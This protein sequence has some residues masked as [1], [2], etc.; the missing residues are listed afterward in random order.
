ME[1]LVRSE[2]EDKK[3]PEVLESEI[4]ENRIEGQ[5]FLRNLRKNYPGVFKAVSTTQAI[6]SLL[7]YEGKTIERLQKRGRIDGGEAAR[8]MSTIDQRFKQ[9]QKSPPSIDTSQVSKK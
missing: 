3:I 5:T 7:S 9:L 8:M 4:N 2:K 6:R 1:S